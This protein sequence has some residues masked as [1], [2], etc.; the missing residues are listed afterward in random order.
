[1][2]VRANDIGVDERGTDA[3]PY[4]LDDRSCVVANGEV[5]G[6][7]EMVDLEPAKATDQLSD[8]SGSLIAGRHRDRVAVVGHDVQHGEVQ[9]AR[10]VQA[11][12]ELTLAARPFAEADVGE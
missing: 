9:V 10:R 2:R 4:V 12:P 1:M 8:R 11:L 6:A 3:G 7:I 5:V